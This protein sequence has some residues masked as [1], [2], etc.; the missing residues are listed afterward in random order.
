MPNLALGKIKV[1]VMDGY[2]SRSARPAFYN[3]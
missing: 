2:K 3:Q 1:G